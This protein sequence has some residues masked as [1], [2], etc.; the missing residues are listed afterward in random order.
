MAAVD[1]NIAVN[2]EVAQLSEVII[3][4]RR[5]LHQWPELGFQEQ[6][7]SALVSGHLRALGLESS[8]PAWRKLES[9][10]HPAWQWSGENGT[11]TGGYGWAPD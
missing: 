10:G 5:I 11:I 2:R 6:R 3:D 9:A 8:G 4:L 1:S 7:T